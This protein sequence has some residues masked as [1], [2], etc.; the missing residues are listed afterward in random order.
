M[1]DSKAA[2]TLVLSD[3][4]GAYKF[5]DGQEAALPKPL[6]DGE[7]WFFFV[8][9]PILKRGRNIRYGLTGDTADGPRRFNLRFQGDTHFD[10]AERNRFSLF[11]RGGGA[12][13]GSPVEIWS[14]IWDEDDALFVVHRS[15]DS[16]AIDWYGTDGTKHAGTPAVETGFKQLDRIVNPFVIGASLPDDELIVLGDGAT[17]GFAGWGGELGFFGAVS[18]A[19]SAADADWAA[20]AQGADPLDRFSAANVMLYRT[21]DGDGGGLDSQSSGDTASAMVTITGSTIFKGSH[22]HP[23]ATG[24]SWDAM[25]WPVWGI[26]PSQS[27]VPVTLSGRASSGTTGTVEVLVY[28][29]DDGVVLQDWT[30]AGSIAGGA[31]STTIDLPITTGGMC[32]AL[33]RLA[34]D[35]DNTVTALH[36]PFGVGPK[37]YLMGQSNFQ[38]ALTTQDL[39]LAPASFTGNVYFAGNY[40][41]S[42]G[43]DVYT[44]RAIEIAGLASDSSDG[45]A[46]MVDQL[47]LYTARGKAPVMICSLAESGSNP[48]QMIAD[49]ATKTAQNNREDWRLWSTVVDNV[50]AWGDD[51]AVIAWLWSGSIIGR[52]D[53]ADIMSATIY[54]SAG[55]PGG[56]SLQSANPSPLAETGRSIADLFDNFDVLFMPV[57]RR[58][59]KTGDSATDDGPFD[60]DNEDQVGVVR[61]KQQAYAEEQG[62]TI[63]P[64][65]TIHRIEPDGPVHQDAAATDGVPW[66]SELF[67][68]GLAWHYGWVDRV[69]VAMAS[70]VFNAGRTTITVTFD[71]IPAGLTLTAA[72]P[73]AVT[74]FEVD[75][76]GTGTA[77]RSGFTAAISGSQVVLT[78]TSGAWS[79]GST[80]YHMRKGP[81]SYGLS[82]DQ[83]PLING[84]LRLTGQPSTTGIGIPV[85]GSEDPVTV[86][87]AA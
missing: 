59:L 48:L 7:A 79:A 15:G 83:T 2:D 39:D 32:K 16:F 63:G 23:A 56:S 31:W 87:D 84:A 14:D 68:T 73:T 61:E 80:L 70:A 41:N 60:T 27:T 67:M 4:A 78:K 37:I 75:D 65:P 64:P 10:S 71:P 74:G 8:R 21:P 33:A 77:S 5:P 20:I 30:S 62:W 57:T 55:A 51:N 43:Q 72:A 86:A 22:I 53:Q 76:G 40:R 36:E 18:A 35:P 11:M 42:S 29:A 28:Q 12:S 24:L 26:L 13:P 1:E 45:L 58:R 82:V 6:A 81:Q 50:T 54:G 44:R 19:E 85:S 66:L 69:E 47:N 9:F 38:L 17:S 49:D 25:P 46:T 52:S 3:Y 34:A